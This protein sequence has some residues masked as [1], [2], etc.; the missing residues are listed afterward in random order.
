[1]KILTNAFTSY[2]LA[3]EEL[4]AGL[5]LSPLQQAVIRNHI[6][7]YA[8]QKLGMEF[9]NRNPMEFGIQIALLDGK[10]GALQLLLDESDEAFQLSL[11]QSKTAAQSQE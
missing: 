2:D 6:S 7:G 9:D 8:H 5:I 1:M 10:I 11:A 3:A 4:S